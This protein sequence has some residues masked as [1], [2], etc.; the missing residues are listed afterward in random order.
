VRYALAA[1]SI[2]ER[3]LSGDEW[4]FG[5]PLLLLHA[6]TWLE[7]FAAVD[8]EAATAQAMP[9]IAEPARLVDVRG[10]QAL[11]WFE[12]GRLAEAAQAAR[13]ADA[14]ARRLGFQDHPWAVNY[15]RVLAGTALEQRDF[16]TAEQL[17]ERAL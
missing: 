2:E 7:D 5:V 16:G 8:R 14:D 17:T 11:A 13:V 6:Y 12:A 1:R 9:S 3:T 4:G 15:L 10:A